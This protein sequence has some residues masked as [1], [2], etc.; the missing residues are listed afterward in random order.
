MQ[1]TASFLT[2]LDKML[3]IRIFNKFQSIM[4]FTNVVKDS[5]ICPKT[6]AQKRV[7]EKRGDNY[8]EF[9]NLWRKTSEFAKAR[10]RYILG[11]KGIPMVNPDG[12]GT[13]FYKLAPVD[14]YYSF[15]IWSQSL[16]KLNLCA[17]RFW[18]W[19]FNNP[20]LDMLLD[21]KYPLAHDILFA[22]Y[23]S[24][25]KLEQQ[26]EKGII[27]VYDFSFILSAWIMDFSEPP[28][29]FDYPIVKKIHLS[30]NDDTN[31]PK[32]VEL[33]ADWVFQGDKKGIVDLGEMTDNIFVSK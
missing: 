20:K 22:D 1:G 6:V 2:G 23:S 7:A 17:E 10:Q 27:Y 8:T 12:G 24:D 16:N 29:N 5:A 11:K 28:G 25:H 15:Y 3:Q 19:L 32:Y 9:F 13:K 4:G 31:H 30:L 18:F 26:Y 33:F 14:L 21:D